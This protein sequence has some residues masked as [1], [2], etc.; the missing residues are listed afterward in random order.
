ML[1]LLT[2][3]PLKSPNRKASVNG[4]LRGRMVGISRQTAFVIFSRCI[5]HIPDAGVSSTEKVKVVQ[6]PRKV[7]SCEFMPIGCCKIMDF[8]PSIVNFSGLW[9]K[10]GFGDAAKKGSSKGIKSPTISSK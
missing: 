7:D 9:G 1:H 6:Q 2:I 8:L 10:D 3:T 5:A 4:R